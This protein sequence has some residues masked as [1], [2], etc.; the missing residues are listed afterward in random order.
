MKC[1]EIS[2][3]FADAFGCLACAFAGTFA[4]V[5]AAAA[6]VTASTSPLRGRG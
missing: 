2:G 5:A 1:D 3:T 4:D 6:N